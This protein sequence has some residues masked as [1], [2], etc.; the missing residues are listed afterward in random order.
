MKKTTAVMM[1]LLAALAGGAVLIAGG[2]STPVADVTA[3]VPVAPLVVTQ[4]QPAAPLVVTQDKAIVYCCGGGPADTLVGATAEP[5]ETLVSAQDKKPVKDKDEPK[6]G[7]AK[8]SGIKVPTGGFPSL[9][10]KAPGKDVPCLPPNIS[11]SQTRNFGDTSAP[12]GPDFGSIYTDTQTTGPAVTNPKPSFFGRTFRIQL[13]DCCKA[14]SG[15]LTVVYFARIPGGPVSGP[16]SSN[17]TGGIVENGLPVNGSYGFIGDL[18]GMIAT[19]WAGTVTRNYTVPLSA[20]NSN[21][22]SFHA[23]E[24]ATV[25]SATLN[26]K[27]CCKV[28][29]DK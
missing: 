27:G 6:I 29:T 22:V 18:N 3:S 9:I 4:E 10:Q 17:D 24:N 2:G 7:E 19:V 11:F 8:K 25:L 5:A 15:T 21:T 20:L 14:T 16:N 28:K 13:P 1:M 12:F 23:A 26:I